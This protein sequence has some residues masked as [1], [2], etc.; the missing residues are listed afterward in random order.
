[1]TIRIVSS[2]VLLIAALL[3]GCGGNSYIVLLEDPGG[4]T[5]KIQVAGKSGEQ[6]VELAS[7]GALLD[8]SEAPA[9]VSEEKIQRD[10]GAAIA[11]RPLLPTR[12]LLYFMSGGTQLTPESEAM[13][14]EIIASVAQRPGVDVSIIGH[15]DTVGAAEQNTALALQ[16]AKE[17]GELLKA[18]GLMANEVTIASHGKSNLLVKTPDNTPESRNRRVEISVR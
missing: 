13:L 11:A 17:V 10:F 4:G 8:G 5:G 3:S 18:Q 6:T 14:P 15:T 7:T 16:R 1:M 9:P 12:Y 2:V